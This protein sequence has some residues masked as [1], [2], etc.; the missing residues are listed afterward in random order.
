MSHKSGHVIIDFAP[1]LTPHEVGEQ[2][3]AHVAVP[4]VSKVSVEVNFPAGTTADAQ[5]KLYRKVERL[6]EKLCHNEDEDSE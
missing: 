4:Y 1:V 2:V 6:C 5:V 3:A